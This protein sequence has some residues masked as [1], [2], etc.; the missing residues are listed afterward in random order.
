MKHSFNIHPSLFILTPMPE[1]SII[2]RID[3]LSENDCH[4]DEDRMKLMLRCNVDMD[5]CLLLELLDEKLVQLKPANFKG[6]RY[7]ITYVPVLN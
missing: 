6:E 5:A 4:I 7:A 3:D 2:Q 1:Q